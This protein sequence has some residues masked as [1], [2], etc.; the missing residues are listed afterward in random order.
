M[1]LQVFVDTK[2]KVNCWIFGIISVGQTMTSIR[3]TDS[4]TAGILLVLSSLTP[5]T[6]IRN[7]TLRKDRP[8]IGLWDDDG[9][10]AAARAVQA[11]L[12]RASLSST[13]AVFV[14]AIYGGY[15]W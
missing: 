12:V 8:R 4:S 6:H 3:A 11:Y 9:L 1:P 7:S 14:D 5:S 10:N 2:R 15:A 13:L